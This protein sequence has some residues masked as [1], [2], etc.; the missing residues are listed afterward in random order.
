MV[1]KKASNHLAR[2]NFFAGFGTL[3]SGTIF[4]S[5]AI[6]ILGVEIPGLEN[7]FPFLFVT[8]VLPSYRGK[9][10]CIFHYVPVV[11]KLTKRSSFKTAISN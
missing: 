7:P 11:V 4:L 1:L 3:I 8:V 9:L 5:V 10:N 2:S 6:F